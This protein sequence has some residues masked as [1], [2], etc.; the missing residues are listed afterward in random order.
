MSCDV[1]ATI[2]RCHFIS[3]HHSVLIPPR[4]FVSEPA[5]QTVLNEAQNRNPVVESTTSNTGQSE[6]YI[7]VHIRCFHL[8]RCF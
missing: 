5:L 1:S 4:L 8:D 3:F 7:C 6:V 2:R